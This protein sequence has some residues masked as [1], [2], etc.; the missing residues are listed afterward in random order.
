[1]QSL[2]R[3][4]FL[5]SSAAIG[6]A[7]CAPISRTRLASG[8]GAAA[9]ARALYSRIFEEMLVASP[10]TATRL[11]LDTGKRAAL[12]SRLADA[13]PAGKLNYYAPLA[14][15]F[16]E[17]K[18]IPRDQL[19]GR[20]RAWLD[21]AL[22]FSERSREIES[23]PYGAIGGYSYPVPYVL[24]QL[25]GSYQSVPDFL[26]SQHNIENGADAQAYLDRLERFHRNIDLDIETAKSDGARGVIPPATILEKAL[27]QTR[28]LRAERGHSAGLVTSLARRTSEKQISGD[29]QARA[30][31][32]VDGPIA[33]A[34]DR[35]MALLEDWR[36]QAS[37]T[38]GVSRLPEGE[39]LYAQALRFHTSTNLSA[40]EIHQIGLEQVSE[41]NAQAEPLLRKEGLTAGS[42]GRRIAELS[43]M[44]KHLFANND[45]GRQQLLETIR[46]DLSRLRTRMPE[47]FYSLPTSGMEVR[48]VPLATQLGSPSAYAKSGS[49]DG[50]RPGVYYINL[51]ST[52]SWP[53]WALPT[54]NSHEAI[55]GHL[56]QGAIQKPAENIPL[57]F[58]SVEIP[59]FGE[60]WGLYAETLRDELDLYDDDPLGR[61]GMIQ[62]FLFRAARLVVDTGM[63]S[64]AWSRDRAVRYF[65]DTVGREQ[66]SSER[67]I[68]R[69]LVWPGQATS[70]KIGHNEI[71]RIRDHTRRRLGS[72]FDIK[73]FHDLVLLSS[74]M[75]LEVL[76]SLA[77][78]WEGGRLS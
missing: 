12:K 76:S 36:R 9:Q 67:E 70:Y 39:R 7:A 28:S 10:E 62:S 50:S 44:D 37:D 23:I 24:S 75:P 34:L 45:A 74:D 19:E 42:V 21:T 46:E 2:S 43:R 5:L 57:L 68:D 41:L 60:G 17:L 29:W 25:T 14:R 58:R 72:R 71:L 73:A 32:I 4:T 63:H 33:A 56:W 59:A 64:M 54:L 3:R 8:L 22:W 20:D 38:P 69:Y 77:N 35:Q 40:A 78:D 6:A 65:M 48:R 16:A 1:M 13:S 49:V 11:G 31:R 53:R 15:A 52:A 47:L 55:P 27:A 61:I 66:L 51:T 30:T 18:A 26:N